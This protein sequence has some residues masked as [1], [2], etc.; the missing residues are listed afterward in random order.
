M[1]CNPLRWLWGLGALLPLLILSLISSRASIEADLKARA[2][3][4][5]KGKGFGWAEVAME[6][7]N[8]RVIGRAVDETDPDKALKIV[9]DISGMRDVANGAS[10]IDKVDK[11]EWTALRRDN[12]IRINGLVPNEKTR[13]DVLGM[14]KGTFPGLQVE[15]N[16]KL[17]RGAPPLDTWL[18]GVGFGLKQLA[19]LK[20]GQVDLEQTA[21]TVTGESN[22]IAAYRSVRSSLAGGLPK[23]VQLKKDAVRPPLAKPYVWSAKHV[24][25]RVVLTGHVP[26]DQVRESLVGAAR[27]AHPKANVIDEMQLADG[28]PDGF[29]AATAAVLAEFA[30]IEEARAEFKDAAATVS[31]FAESAAKADAVRGTLRKSI[32][33][34]FKISEQI[35]YREPPVK[36]ANPYVTAASVDAGTVVLTGFV[37]SDDARQSIVA[38][39]RQRF[40]GRTVRDQMEIA[41][42]QPAGWQ[43]CVEAGFGALGRLGSGRASLTDRRLEVVGATDAEALAQALPGEVR[44]AAGRDC[45]SD[46][47]LTLNPRPDSGRAE[48]EARAKAEAEA[49]TKAEAEARSAEARAKAEADVRMKAD[50]EARAKAAA[51]S[52]AAVAADA[53]LKAE[54]EARRQ[55]QAVSCQETLRSVVKA[56]VINF[57]RASAE[58]DAASFATLNKLAEVAGKCP[59]VA[60]NVEGHTDADGTSERNQSLSE[61]RARSVVDYLVRAGVVAGRL[62]AIGYGE[63]RSIAP[64]DTT[65]NKAKNRRIEFSV[66]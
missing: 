55:Q 65:E 13:L 7:R 4:A 36:T 61:R 27:R 51:A 12:K 26:S 62:D 63:T 15:D 39:A 40:I 48:A 20:Q 23:G 25:D 10:L 41:S 57:K 64:N 14:V 46:V 35:K 8:A 38:A 5:L 24:G 19:Q 50:A 22:D 44:T 32:P 59:D 21:L 66:K 1:K 6:G 49:R 9:Y 56:G 43:K 37:P 42:G 2:E 58:I 30:V 54:A 11:Y 31:G 53:R 34:A 33:A 60:I 45:D 16:M 52:S 28:A 18:G 29:A 17:A 3:Q 47:R